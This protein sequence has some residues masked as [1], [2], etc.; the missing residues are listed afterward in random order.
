[1]KVR[2][3]TKVAVRKQRVSNTIVPIVAEIDFRLE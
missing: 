1:M 2:A 3:A